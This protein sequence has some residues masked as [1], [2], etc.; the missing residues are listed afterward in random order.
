MKRKGF[1]LI[2]LLA[3]II[4][5]A[6]I[7]LIATP[8]ILG[9]IDNAKKNSFKASAL[10][11]GESARNAFVKMMYSGGESKNVIFTY[12]NGVESSNPNGYVL[13][14]QGQKPQNG[15]I[16][17][18]ANG[19]VAIAIYDGKWCATKGFMSSDVTVDAMSEEDCL[20]NSTPPVITISG[21]NPLNINLDS[22]YSDI[23]VTANDA[24]EGPVSVTRS[25]T[26]DT[27]TPGTYTLTYSAEDSFGNIAQVTRQVIVR[28]ILSGDSLIAI[29][30]NN[31]RASGD[32]EFIVNGVTY[33]VEYIAIDGNT[34]YSS[35]T[36]LGN[37]TN[38]TKMLVVKYNGNL[39]VNAGVTL[40]AAA[41]KR[42]MFLYVTGDLTNNGTI[43]MTAR[44][45]SAPGQDVYLYKIDATTYDYVPA[46][47]SAGGASI[48]TNNGI[49]FCY[50]GNPGIAGASRGTGGGGGGGLRGPSA[51]GATSGAGSAGTSYSGGAGG[52]GNNAASTA[53]SGAVNGGAGGNAGGDSG[54]GAGNPGGNGSGTGVAGSSGTGG[55]LIIR[56][57]N[58][59]NNGTISSNGSNGGDGS[60][61]GT[62]GASGGGSINLFYVNS[63]TAGTTA[64]N[65]G[66]GGLGFLGSRGG[67]GGAGTVT[68]K[69]ITN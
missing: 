37:T 20:L 57:N 30:K 13:N 55:L 14:Y 65:G 47:G 34:T 9:I 38:D 33:A 39:T 24:S 45:A 69:Q 43:T 35:S 11:I 22:V 61:A 46:S 49:G 56:A 66:I 60:Y 67:A 59:I 4:I 18:R 44:G 1:T 23:D 25:G 53:G 12:T 62:G 54:G 26:L 7:A 36:N 3:V 21:D 17:L 32:Y 50:S 64:A 63:L 6:V 15:R 2:E 27:S 68:T 5:L 42:G 40:T 28:A 19:K 31:T 41:R 16:S 48:Y 51:G 8:I 58:L 52:G 29:V 10:G